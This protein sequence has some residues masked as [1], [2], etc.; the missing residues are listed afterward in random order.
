M[1]DSKVCEAKADCKSCEEK[2]PNA[3]GAIPVAPVVVPNATGPAPV[4]EKRLYKYTYRNDVPVRYIM[5]SFV[6]TDHDVSVLCEP[7]VVYV[8]ALGMQVVTAA[9]METARGELQTIRNLAYK[10]RP[11][12][13]GTGER[14]ECLELNDCY[15]DYRPLLVSLQAKLNR[16]AVL[17]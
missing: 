8:G 1:A 16:M 7:Y 11:I 2:A 17:L 15:R 13:I 9:E 10:T 4:G 12:T 3:T 6:P 5:A 14:V